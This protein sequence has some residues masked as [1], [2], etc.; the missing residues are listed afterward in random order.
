MMRKAS[1]FVIAGAIVSAAPA[2]AADTYMKIEGI[3]GEAAVEE[4]IDSWSFGTCLAGVCHKVVSPRDSAS[5]QASGK[6][7]QGVTKLTASQNSHSLR[8]AGSGGGAGK[9][10]MSDLSVS[11][12]GGDLDGDGR[13]D[14]AFAATQPE[15]TGLTLNFDKASPQLAK[16]CSGKHFDKVTLRTAAG[17]SFEVTGASVTCSDAPAG[18]AGRSQMPNRISMN[19][20]TPKM[21]QG[22]TFG[23]RCQAGLACSASITFSG[24][25]MK[26]TKTGHVTILK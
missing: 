26:H 18:T 6:R 17:D 19:V 14:L 12:I 9:A 13:P 7:G 22:A 1:M 15:V 24:G 3:E 10:S 16:I 4:P 2:M 25:Q 23:E 5:G 20:T 11:R 21:T 8:G